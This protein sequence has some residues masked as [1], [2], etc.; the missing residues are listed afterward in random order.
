MKVLIL[1]SGSKIGLAGE[2]KEV[3]EGYARNYLI[4]SGIVS[5]VNK[6]SLSIFES[7][8]NKIKKKN[9]AYKK[10]KIGLAKKLNRK[11]FVIKSKSDEKGTLYAQ[12]DKKIISDE[13]KKQGYIV[14]INEVILKEK[15]KKLGKKKVELNIAS[16]KAI[17]TIEVKS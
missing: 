9:S 10:E 5:P 15:I 6:H 3:K 8:K 14:D 11:K 7:Q 13:L 17:I 2:I 4:P 12:V 1:K 16:K